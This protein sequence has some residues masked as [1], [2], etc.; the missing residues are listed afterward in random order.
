MKIGNRIKKLREYNNYTQDWM[1]SQLGISQRAYSKI[2][3]DEVAISIDKLLSIS[4][5]LGVNASEFLNKDGKHIY[6]NLAQ[7]QKGG[8]AFVI[9][10]AEKALDLYDKLLAEKDAH[11]LTLQKLV[12]KL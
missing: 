2:E 10:Q 4:E 8:N 1:A 9:N 11:I 12:Q 3:N 7:N 5:L 6:N